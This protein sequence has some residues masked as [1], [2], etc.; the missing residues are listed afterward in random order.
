MQD[1]LNPFE[2]GKAKLPSAL[3]VLTILTFIGS[4]ILLLLTLASPAITKF[5]LGMIDKGMASGREFSDK[6]IQE[7]RKGREVLEI[8]QANMVP[9]MIIGIIGIGLCIMGALWMRQLKKDGFWIYL[10]GQVL[11]IVGGLIL[12]GTAQ[13]T[14]VSSVVTSI[15]I[16]VLFIILYAV[17]RKHLVN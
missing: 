8:M 9:M 12:V 16:P 10:A 15:G 14:G 1:N 11:P 3:N 6:E 5:F 13:Y 7:M 17:Q 4:G 2:E